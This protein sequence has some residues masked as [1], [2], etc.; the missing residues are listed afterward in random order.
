[1]REDQHVSETAV[2]AEIIRKSPAEIIIDQHAPIICVEGEIRGIEAHA[3]KPY[4]V[5]ERREFL[6]LDGFIQYVSDHEYVATKVFFVGN[7]NGIAAEAIMDYHQGQDPS[8]C[9]H[10]ALFASEIHDDF[11]FWSGKKWMT[12]EMAASMLEQQYK[13]IIDPDSATLVE[14]I[15]KFY[16]TSTKTVSR[17]IDRTTGS[18]VA[19]YSDET[20]EKST[21]KIPKIIEVATPI[22]KGG[23]PVAYPIH[24][25][26]RITGDRPEFQFDMV[27]RDVLLEQAAGLMLEAIREGIESP[28]YEGAVL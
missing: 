5:R 21:V 8:W 15:D 25:R 16:A 3:D 7:R 23:K 1:M 14:L 17:K 20:N 11:S 6:N 27:D 24:V 10:R 4:R 18:I 22:F 9:T 26:Y 2:L 19:Q 28:V 13:N 12:Q